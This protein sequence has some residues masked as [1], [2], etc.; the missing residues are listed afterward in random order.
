MI[1]IF[2]TS[3]CPKCALL[4]NELII[5]NILYREYDMNDTNTL[6][7]LYANG[8]FTLSAPILQVNENYYTIDRLFDG[9][10]LIFDI[11][12]LVGC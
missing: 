11:K 7:E 8:I 4:K 9:N 12:T 5:N 2:F 3:N 6:T 10:T 1:N